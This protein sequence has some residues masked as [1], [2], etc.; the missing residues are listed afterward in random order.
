MQPPGSA[1]RL[2]RIDDALYV[3]FVTFSCYHRRRLLDHDQS[4][5]IVLGVLTEE[6]Q[7]FAARCVGFVLMPDHV[8]ALI[9]F[10]R[11]GQ[12]S[13]FLQQWKGRSSTRIKKLLREELTHYAMTI[14]ASDPIWQTRFHAFEI[15]SRSKLEE[16]LEYMHLNPVRARLVERAADWRWSSARWY[17]EKQTVGVPIQWVD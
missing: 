3:H 5:R 16:K 2:Q 6:L 14:S 10:S 17:L 1:N 7:K 11:T 4:K 15:E 13:R 8:H 9:W 12:L